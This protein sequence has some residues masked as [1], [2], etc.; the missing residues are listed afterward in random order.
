M[1][2]GGSNRTVAELVPGVVEAL[3]Q[4]TDVTDLA[5]KYIRKAIIEIT[6]K[7]PFDELRRTGPQVLVS[8]ADNSISAFMA[9]GGDDYNWAESFCVFVDSPTNTVIDTLDYKTPKAIEILTS[10][11]TTGIPKYWTRYGSN[12]RVAPVPNQPYTMFLRYQVKHPFPKDTSSILALRAQPLYIPDDWEEIVEYAAA[13]RI[14]IV[15]RWNEQASFIHQILYGDPDYELSEGHRGRPGLVAARTLQVERDQ[16]F[17]T[18]QLGIRV[19][20]Y[21]SY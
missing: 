4:R 7:W 5:P 18:R 10:P 13:E 6:S 15:K 20:R 11:V 1:I 3:Q 17:N 19:S 16:Q 9:D 12:F 8:V 14:A 2:P 21:N